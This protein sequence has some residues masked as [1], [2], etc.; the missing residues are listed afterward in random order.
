MDIQQGIAYHIAR[1]GQQYGPFEASRVIE[2]ARSGEIL[3]TDHLW[4]DG[5]A[6]WIPVVTCPQLAGVLKSLA[7]EPASTPVAGT[8]RVPV[9]SGS[10]RQS[11]TGTGQN[12]QQAMVRELE[13]KRRRRRPTQ[14]DIQLKKEYPGVRIYPLILSFFLAA[15]SVTGIVYFH[16]LETRSQSFAINSIEEF[17]SLQYTADTE[18]SANELAQYTCIV[19]VFLALLGYLIFAS[20]NLYLAWRY[21]QD[22]PNPTTT[23]AKAVGFCFVPVFQLIWINTAYNK[24]HSDYEQV[25]SQL[26][27]APDLKAPLFHAPKYL[28]PLLFPFIHLFLAAEMGKATN[29]LA[30]D[31]I[32]RAKE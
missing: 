4:A 25:A 2:M 27:A 21:V 24:W 10:R 16:N 1:E 20:R 23:P 12:R 11:A 17:K 8:D 18:F 31:R 19:L 22:I 28:F 15:A 26:Q 32:R 13:T 29:F 6:Q 5:M 9:A 3:P 14:R 30:A 7:P